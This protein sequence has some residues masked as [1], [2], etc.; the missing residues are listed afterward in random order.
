[1]EALIDTV[2][3]ELASSPKMELPTSVIGER[4]MAGLRQLDY[5]AYIRFVSVYRKFEDVD[6]FLLEINKM[7][8]GDK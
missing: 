6:S 8:Q 3:N 5:V 2:E 1:M 7:K 4:V